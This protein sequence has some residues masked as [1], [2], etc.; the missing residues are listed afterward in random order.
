MIFPSL[1]LEKTKKLAHQ[2]ALNLYP[3]MSLCFYGDLG[4]GKTTFVRS[5]LETL[6]PSLEEVP[7]PT[8]TLIQ[9]YSTEVGQVWHCDF[10]RLKNPE[11][12]FELGIEEM[13]HS[14]ICLVE[15]PEKID[16]YLPP[17]RVDV[18]INICRNSRREISLHRQ[19]NI[20]DPFLSLPF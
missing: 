19:G 20:R 1:T 7:S 18:H 11:E 8:F 2:I 16:P 14:G 15:W 5:I 4:V 3:G 13:F 12:V 6:D 9:Y 17:N 10:Y